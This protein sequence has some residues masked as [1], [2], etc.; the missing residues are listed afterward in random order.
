LFY[1]GQTKPEHTFCA[2]TAVDYLFVQIMELKKT[3]TQPYGNSG[4]SKLEGNLANVEHY[5]LFCGLFLCVELL[6]PGE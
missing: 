5:F 2:L 1:C 3:V 6:L 4:L